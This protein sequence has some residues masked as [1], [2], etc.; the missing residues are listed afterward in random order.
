MEVKTY[1]PAKKI[2]VV[3]RWR[4]SIILWVFLRGGGACCILPQYFNLQWRLCK[5]PPHKLVIYHGQW[6]QMRDSLSVSPTGVW[7]LSDTS[8]SLNGTLSLWISHWVRFFWLFKSQ[9]TGFL[10]R[11]PCTSLLQRLY[12]FSKSP[13]ILSQHG[14][15]VLG[16]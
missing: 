15:T 7:A 6:R 1:T 9:T 12:C 3:N 11:H 14:E 16:R 4:T 5:F 2:N 8:L 13:L 10:K